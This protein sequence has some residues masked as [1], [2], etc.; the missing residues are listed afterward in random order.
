MLVTSLVL[1]WMSV[2]A[3]P[4]D[5]LALPEVSYKLT[6]RPW[7]PLNVPKSRYLEVLEELCRFSLKFQDHT[8]AIIDSY[9]HQPNS[10][11]TESFLAVGGGESIMSDSE[12]LR[13]TFGDIQPVRAGSVDGTN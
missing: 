5:R 13:S 4:P 3:E 9:T 7:A 12:T 8:S 2:A 11:D 10:G 6:S 1:A